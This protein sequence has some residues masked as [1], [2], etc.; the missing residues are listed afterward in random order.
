MPGIEYAFVIVLLLA[1]FPFAMAQMGAALDEEDIES[2]FA[3]T[4]VASSIAGLPFVAT[5]LTA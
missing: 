4:C 5:L 1:V 2:F 3:W